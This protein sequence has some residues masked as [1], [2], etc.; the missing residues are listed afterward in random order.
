MMPGASVTSAAPRRGAV[1]ALDSD[2]TERLYPSRSPSQRNA[3]RLGRKQYSPAV[4]VVFHIAYF[5]IRRRADVV[6]RREYET[7]PFAAQKILERC[8]FRLRRF[9]F[10]N[11][12]VEAEYYECVRIS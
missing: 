1:S 5:K 4:M 2:R 6:M 3:L 7:R 12:V 10:R 11:H 8:D 9:F